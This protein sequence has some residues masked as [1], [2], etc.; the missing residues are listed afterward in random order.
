MEGGR[1]ASQAATGPPELS[2]ATCQTGTV[3]T[4]LSWPG[5]PRRPRLE[6][7]PRRWPPL[8]TQEGEGQHRSAYVSNVGIVYKPVEVSAYGP[9]PTQSPRPH[10]QDAEHDGWRGAARQHVSPADRKANPNHQDHEP[11][12]RRCANV[13]SLPSPFSLSLPLFSSRL[14]GSA[15]KWRW[16]DENGEA[17]HAGVGDGRRYMPL[18]T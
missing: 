5:S 2:A 6:H 7:R 18:V 13:S 1:C 12:R 17:Q 3:V 14:L 9:P 16:P 10:P 4:T 15:V 8:S 11:Y